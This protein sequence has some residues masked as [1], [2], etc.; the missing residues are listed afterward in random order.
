[1]WSSVFPEHSW[2]L[3]MEVTHKWRIKWENI[4]ALRIHFGMEYVICFRKDTD[5][6][7][8]FRIPQWSWHMTKPNEEK[9]EF[10]CDL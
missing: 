6:S 5:I 3:A 4:Q 9:N 1:M 10:T 8:M 7:D 2:K